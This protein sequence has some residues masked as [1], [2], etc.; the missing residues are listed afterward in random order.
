[1]KC[2]LHSWKLNPATMTYASAGPVILGATI[3]KGEVH[4]P[5]YAIAKNADGTCTLTPPAGTGGG[6]SVC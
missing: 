4:Q 6:C 5:E 2:T 1:M 3:Q